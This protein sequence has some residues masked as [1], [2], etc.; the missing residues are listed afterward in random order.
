VFLQLLSRVTDASQKWKRKRQDGEETG[1]DEENVSPVMKKKRTSGRMDKGKGKEREREKEKPEKENRK[2]KR[3]VRKK[4]RMQGKET[5]VS[6]G[7]T[8]ELAQAPPVKPRPK[9][10]PVTVKTREVDDRGEGS[11]RQVQKVTV[12]DRGMAEDASGPSQ[13]KAIEQVQRP[14][15]QMAEHRQP[16]VRP[17]AIAELRRRREE[18][19]K[20]F[21]ASTIPPAPK[22][23]AVPASKAPTTPGPKTRQPIAATP[24][25]AKTR[26]AIA[27]TPGPKTRQMAAATPGPKT[28]QAAARDK[29]ANDRGLRSRKG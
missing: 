10:R 1:G 11:S 25:G 15:A 5:E 23:P 21:C 17:M 29:S 2:E 26:Q 9:P 12:D 8:E 24:A 7:S 6:S 28:R 18:Q 22:T 19:L 27:A 4:A 3:K 16:T 13:D 20:I 14:Q